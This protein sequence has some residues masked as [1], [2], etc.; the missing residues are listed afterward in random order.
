VCVWV[1]PEAHLLSEGLVAEADSCRKS[2]Q[3]GQGEIA[4]RATGTG[5]RRF[6]PSHS[7]HAPEEAIFS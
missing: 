7:V 4:G 6:L 5:R 3:Y 2:L 1:I